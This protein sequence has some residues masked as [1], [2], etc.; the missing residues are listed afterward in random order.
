MHSMLKLRSDSI[1]AFSARQASYYP[2]LAEQ[3]KD[4]ARGEPMT[5]HDP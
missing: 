4:V 1:V 5:L 2:T 3:N